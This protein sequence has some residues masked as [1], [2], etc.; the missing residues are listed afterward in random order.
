MF[1]ETVCFS[2]DMNFIVFK[3]WV[4]YEI[5]RILPKS[6][7]MKCHFLQVLQPG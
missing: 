3:A 6:C 5:M 4:V 2:A 7:F 1:N